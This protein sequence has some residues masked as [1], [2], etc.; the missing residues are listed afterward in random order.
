MKGVFTALISPFAAD[1]SVDLPAF[2]KIL[3][4]Q[5]QAGVSGVI[6][7]G[8]T[9]ESPTLTQ[10][11]KQTLIRTA[12]EVLKGTKVKVL[13]GTGSNNT[14][15]TVRFSRW[16]SEQGVDGVLIVSPYYN[17]PT[18]A[19]LIEHFQAVANAVT[20]KCEIMLYNVPSRTGVSIA[21][22]S[23]VRLAEN[24]KITSLKEAS[25]SVS[26]TSAILDQLSASQRKLDILAGDDATYLPLL[27]VGAVGVVS[28]AS[29]LFPRAMVQ[30]QTAMEQGNIERAR[31]VHRKYY[32][33]FRD[34]FIDSNPVPVKYAMQHAGWCSAKVR[35]PLLEMNAPQADI[36]LASLKRCG[37][38]ASRSGSKA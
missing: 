35:L 30:I 10:D 22:E 38:E 34:L 16:A 6:P 33:L 36:L 13:A 5:A 11:E 28:V 4:D 19:G 15:E 7:N 1:G 31:E 18:Q 26:L 23:V 2:R 3:E 27:S 25:G 21:P 14:E 37:I 9:G 12:L 32:P 20:G 8:T 29:N 17:R 24:S